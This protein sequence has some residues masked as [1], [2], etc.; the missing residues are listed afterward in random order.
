MIEILK[1]LAEQEHKQSY[2]KY[3]AFHSMHEAYGVLIEEIL[4]ASEAQDAVEDMQWELFAHIRREKK[5]NAN[6]SMIAMLDMIEDTAINAAKENLQVAA[7]CLKTKASLG[8]K[9]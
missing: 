9:G 6:S 3:P 2:E 4:E 7:M 8:N 5:L 1:R